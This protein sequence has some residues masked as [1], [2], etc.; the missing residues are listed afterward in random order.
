[1]EEVCPAFFADDRELWSCVICKVIEVELAVRGSV[2]GFSKF[3][4]SEFGVFT[5]RA[6]VTSGPVWIFGTL[7]GADLIFG[8]LF[9]EVDHC[10]EVEVTI[11]IVRISGRSRRLAG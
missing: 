8:H 11:D 4:N 7:S 1:M 9:D 3:H 2:G 6:R 5:D 10:V